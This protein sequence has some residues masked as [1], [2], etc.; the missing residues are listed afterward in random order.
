MANTPRVRIP[1]NTRPVADSLQN[2]FTG[3]GGFNDKIQQ[4]R[5]F[6]AIINQAELEMAYRTDWIARKVVDIPAGDSTRE[7]RSW[8]AD[9]KDITLIEEAE[10]AFT[11]QRKMR[12]ALQKARLYGGSALILGV[13]QGKSDEP[14]IVDRIGKGQL[15]WVHVVSRNQLTPGPI[16]RDI[17]SPFYGEPQYY[18]R[19][20]VGSAMQLRLHPSRVV[21]LVGLEYPDPETAPDGWGDSVLQVVADSVKAA[22]VVANGI[23]AMVDDAKV[24]VIGIPELT[25]NLDDPTYE[26]R[27]MDRFGVAA[28]AKSVYR[29]LLLDK[30]EEWNRIETNFSTL[31][32]VVKVY[33]LL[34]SAAA[35]IPAT[36]FLAQ[37]PTGMSATGESDVRNYYDRLGTELNTEIRP[38]LAR[39]DEVL[40][41]S[42]FGTRPEDIFYNWNSLWQLDDTQKADLAKKK[43]DIFKI[44]V[45][46]GLMT[47]EVLKE[48]RQN[49][50]I[51]D[52]TY[53]GLEA[54]I[55][56]FDTP[57]DGE[58][59]QEPIKPQGEGEEEPTPEPGAIAATDRFR[60]FKPRDKKIRRVKIKKGKPWYQSDAQ[61][62]TLYVSRPLLN[63]EEVAAWYKGQGFEVTVGAEMH[64]TVAY[65]RMAIDWAKVSEDWGQDDKGHILVRPGGMRIMEQFQDATVLLFSSNYLSW[66]WC[67]I[68]EAG[69]SWDWD[70]YQPHVTIS[71]Q[72][73]KNLKKVQPFQGALQFGPEKFEEISE[74]FRERLVEDA[75]AKKLWA[76]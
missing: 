49:Q 11:L 13:D 48:A 65:S 44:D 21:R 24:D 9:N 38:V 73:P 40:L 12:V 28:R 15:K 53:P 1:R 75:K 69:A 47:R 4:A 52:G 66:R 39:L 56:E 8:Q 70:D 63:W 17:E 23:A 42:I 67:G 26:Q 68:K 76:K 35:D 27:L 50:L 16:E 51:E 6:G 18:D 57:I 22:G 30:E 61:P 20:T 71:Y 5:W 2:L 72:G 32:D 10:R 43:A 36:R 25:A 54:A 34:A 29:M 31:P 3:M 55:E 37:S 60:I 62:R 45:D 33:L 59:P 74:D 41:R 14:L 58:E 19:Q 46:A 7:W 64:V